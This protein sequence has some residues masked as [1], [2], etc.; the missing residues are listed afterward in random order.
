MLAQGKIVALVLAIFFAC[1]G[2]AQ[3]EVI[4][5][6]GTD[7]PAT[8]TCTQTSCPSL[9]QALAFAAAGDTIQLEE[10]RYTVT[11]GTP[12]IVNRDLTIH[13]AGATIDGQD[14]LNAQHEQIRIMHITAGALAIDDLTFV[15]GR[16]GHDEACYSGCSTITS[17]GGGAIFQQSSG[18]LTLDHVN[19]FDNYAP[20]G[21]AISAT[22]PVYISDANF[23]SNSATFGGGVLVR[24]NS[25]IR[26][27]TLSNASGSTAGGAIFIQRGIVTVLD[28]TVA[29]NGAS[30]TIGGGITNLAGNL[31]LMG[32]T[33]GGNLRGALET[34]QN[35][36]TSVRDTIFGQPGYS[37]FRNGAC[38]SANQDLTGSL[39]GR[40]TAA[41]ISQDNGSNLA[42]DDTCGLSNPQ[43]P[44]LAPLADNGGPTPTMAVLFGSPALDQGA[45]C[46]DT[47][48]RGTLRPQGAACDIGAF[49]A[50]FDPQH[51]KPDITSESADGIDLSSATLHAVFDL[52]GEAGELHFLYGTS[53]SA[54]DQ[55]TPGIGVYAAGDGSESLSNLT[56]GTTYYYQPVVLNASG[57]KTDA[58]IQQFTTPVGAPEITNHF[59]G[60]ATDTTAELHFTVAPNGADTDYVITYEAAD[61]RISTDPVTLKAADG[62]QN[63]TRTLTGL[64]PDTT[65]DVSVK[66]T[67]SEGSDTAAFAT[68]TTAEQVTGDAGKELSFDYSTVADECAQ[69]ASITWGDGSQADTV[70]VDCSDAGGD[71]YQ[72]DISVKHTYRQP[73]HFEIQVFFGDFQQD[74]L[75]AAIGGQ[76]PPEVTDLYVDSYD[77]TSA[78]LKFT[79]NGN[80]Q[81][82]TYVI[83]YDDGSGP[84]KTAPADAGAGEITRT[85][86]GLKPGT[87]YTFDVIATSAA[88]S[89]SSDFGPQ[90]ITTVR[91]LAGTAGATVTYTANNSFDVCPTPM[92][93]DW[94]D[95]TSEPLDIHCQPDGSYTTSASHTYASPGRFHIRAVYDNE[96]W[97]E[98]YAVI[99]AVQQQPSPTP[100][101]TPTPTPTPTPPVTPTPVFHQDVVVKPVSG[102]VKVK[103]KGTNKFVALPADGKIPLGSEIDVTK[104]K[105]TLTSVPKAGGTP[106]TA[107]FYAGI[108]KI[109]QVGGITNLTLS[110]PLSCP[111]KGKASAAAKKVKKRRLWGSGKGSFRTTGRYSAATIRGTTWLVQDTCTST[112]TK[113]KQG[114][115]SVRDN[116]RHKTKLV[117]APHS[118]TA[119]VK[120]KKRKR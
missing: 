102:V 41:P 18:Q 82:T 45:G 47:D 11:Q 25:T 87:D 46:D 50:T 111:K 36:F 52:H 74:Q 53:S 65:Y 26:N 5:V 16:D 96:T 104:G 109:T 59:F 58:P 119:H 113:V 44:K 63:I 43:D 37:D 51:R 112:L 8:G 66:A 72:L 98:A 70:P 69:N 62:E 54:L 84:V 30:S 76:A 81:P 7:D 2:S 15:N 33:F 88:G 110:Q 68:F 3:A 71:R 17:N 80:G 21:G 6:T 67:N 13:G 100:T 57:I 55:H 116:V 10:K 24:A 95:G 31:T 106:Q 56:P 114:V 91:Q 60:G 49:E 117:R 103:L 22:G 73:G 118:Y 14:N 38:V 4:N 27:S 32:V 120:N 35:G 78:T 40:R 94:G 93:I 85:I 9:R 34:D 64:Q 90:E 12:L 77:D 105:I 42:A 101:A 19:F 86:S 97:D 83:S 108:F 79:I 61:Q 107:T 23:D 29:G 99:S 75:Y 92:T 1:A 28:S 89:A 39:S 20:V 115:V 48:Q